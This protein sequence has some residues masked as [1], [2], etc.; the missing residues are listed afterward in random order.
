MHKLPTSDIVTYLKAAKRPE[1]MSIQENGYDSYRESVLYQRFIDLP[2]QPPYTNQTI[3]AL[4]DEHIKD[5]CRYFEISIWNRTRDAM[6]TDILTSPLNNEPDWINDLRANNKLVPSYNHNELKHH[7]IHEL[8]QICAYFRIFDFDQD[9]P[10]SDIIDAILD[11]RLNVISRRDSTY[12]HILLNAAD[13][14]WN[15]DDEPPNNFQLFEERQSTVSSHNKE[16]IDGRN[17]T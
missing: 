1:I 6:V 8:L 7:T 17:S 3:N 9:S 4:N 2:V 5:I 10:R 13:T 15:T 14:D 11:H 12:Q 16:S